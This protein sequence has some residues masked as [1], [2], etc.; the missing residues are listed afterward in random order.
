MDAHLVNVKYSGLSIGG[1]EGYG[2]F[3]D[4]DNTKIKSSQTLG[5]RFHGNQA[6]NDDWTVIYTAEFANQ[7]DY[8]NR[9]IDELCYYLGELGTKYKGWLAKVSYELQEGDGSNGFKTPL[10]TNHAFQGWADVFLSTPSIGLEDIYITVTGQ[11]L[12]A[13]VVAIYHD[14]K[15]D[16][17]RND[18]GNE[19]DLLIAKTYAQ[20]N[21]LGIK[22]ANYNAGNA[23][24][25]MSDTNK[26]WLFGQVEF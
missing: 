13:K 14:F 4:Y 16:E 5:L 19:F 24:L 3:L 9:E 7:D 22:Y 10:G 20:S 6:V 8:K 1:L 11:L 23:T 26:L 25:S 2:Y 17:G 15:T 18:A 12:G 21:T